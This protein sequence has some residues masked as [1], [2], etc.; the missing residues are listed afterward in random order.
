MIQLDRSMIHKWIIDKNVNSKDILS[1]F[2]A[3]V[4]GAQS[5]FNL[6]EMVPQT[7]TQGRNDEESH[8][9]KGST[10]TIGVR[11]L[12]SCFYMLGYS[13]N[14]EDGR[15]AFMPSP[16]TLNILSKVDQKEEAKNYL[17]NLF[18]MQYP[19]P[20]DWTPESFQIYFG[21]FIVKLLLDSRINYRLY[22]DEC[23]WFLPFIE[24]IDSVKYEELVESI[25]E[26]R[27]YNYERKKELFESVENYENLFANVTHEINYYFLRLFKDFNVFNLVGDPLHN[28]GK[29]FKFLHSA[30]DTSTTY[31]NDAYQSRKKHSG[32]VELSQVVNES[33][34]KLIDSFSPFELPSRID[35]VEIFS[36]EDWMT[37][38]YQIEPLGYLLCINAQI[39]RNSEIIS[40]VNDM[41]TASKYGSRDGKEFEN[42][43]KPFVKLFKEAINVEILSGPGNTDLLCTM[44]EQPSLT[45][46][47][48]NVEAKTRGSALEGVMATRI[49]KHI[50]K[51]GSK[52]CVIVAPRF[53]KGVYGDIFGNKIVTIRSEEFGNYCYKECKSSANGYADFSSMLNIINN[54]MGTDI[55]NKVRALTESR[56]GFLMA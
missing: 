20:F 53:A 46:Y 23:I 44:E 48:M 51:H 22:I 33:A 42:A 2:T 34:K 32:Y 10:I 35:G 4:S 25:L 21:R 8:A 17:V 24:T 47:N 52:F 55:T 31:R 29:L 27:A 12:Q 43:L 7:I 26:Y 9:N 40:I 1:E 18:C 13:T 49:N 6:E 50:R 30:T 38:I 15:K 45:M 14:L 37:N 5:G 28:E 54:N 39:D 16:M 19:H 3:L 56:Y 11:L 41:I 36:K